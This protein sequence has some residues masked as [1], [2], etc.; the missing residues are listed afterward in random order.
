MLY[1][2]ILLYCDCIKNDK[3]N[4]KQWKIDIQVKWRLLVV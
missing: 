3:R 4:I 2:Y 1:N